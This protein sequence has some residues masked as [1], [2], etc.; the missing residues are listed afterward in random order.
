MDT[1][2]LWPLVTMI[3]RPNA[4]NIG[5]SSTLVARYVVVDFPNDCTYP[6]GLMVHDPN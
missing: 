5:N 2:T 4:D 6:N 3:D 1:T